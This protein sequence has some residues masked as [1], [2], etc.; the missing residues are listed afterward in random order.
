M[1]LNM[2]PEKQ[3]E[4]KNQ[5]HNRDFKRIE[6]KRKPLKPVRLRKTLARHHHLS[7]TAFFKAEENG[8]W[9][10]LLINSDEAVKSN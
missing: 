6:I 2:V 5:Q 3:S 8:R 1:A 7:L 9:E 4:H 10:V